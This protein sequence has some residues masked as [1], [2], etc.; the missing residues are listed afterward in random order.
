MVAQTPVVTVAAGATGTATLNLGSINGFNA[1]VGLACTGPTG[2]TCSLNPTSVTVNGNTTAT[3]TIVAS[4]PA[5]SA[6]KSAGLS[7]RRIGWFA[8]SGGA[9]LACV[10][11]W[12]L[13]A[14]RRRWRALLSLVVLAV[15]AAGIGCGRWRQSS[16]TPPT[17][18]SDTHSLHS[19]CGRHLHHRGDGHAR[20]DHLARNTGDRDRNR[21]LL[22]LASHLRR[23]GIVPAPN[24]ELRASVFVQ[25]GPDSLSNVIVVVCGSTRLGGH[26]KHLLPPDDV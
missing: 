4:T 6:V 1:S 11:L 9:T 17:T 16:T 26:P 20:Y 21:S 15:L 12:G 13:P 24:F 14:R 5:S 23:G 19:N 8:A 25:A 18:H 2:L 3:L 7:S 22:A 10:F